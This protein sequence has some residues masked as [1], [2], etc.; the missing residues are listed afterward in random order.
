[1]KNSTII[2]NGHS[3]ICGTRQ[4]QNIPIVGL[5]PKGNKLYA[6]VKNLAKYEQ[7]NH[8]LNKN[9]NYCFTSLNRTKGPRLWQN[10]KLHGTFPKP[11]QLSNIIN[12]IS[13]KVKEGKLQYPSQIIIGGCRT[14]KSNNTNWVRIIGN[15]APN[16][17]K[18][19]TPTQKS[20]VNS[21]SRSSHNRTCQSRTSP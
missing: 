1:M 20:F 19:F 14:G 7:F 18:S 9:S 3:S 17:L 8:Y 11:L 5:C 13:I 4:N 15:N 16:V 6:S 10:K 21:R 12:Y 2:I